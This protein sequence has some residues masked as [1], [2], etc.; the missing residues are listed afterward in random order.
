MA[1]RLERAVGVKEAA[2]QLGHESPA[3]TGRH[4]IERAST[5]GDYTAVLDRLFSGTAE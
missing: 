4:Y 2:R 5:A 1:T 3:I